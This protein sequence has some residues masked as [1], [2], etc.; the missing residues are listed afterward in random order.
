MLHVMSHT[1]ACLP[2]SGWLSCWLAGWLVEAVRQETHQLCTTELKTPV[3]FV[4]GSDSV[5]NGCLIC[6]WLH[7]NRL[8]ISHAALLWKQ[9]RT[10]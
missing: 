2:G 3:R 10:L 7:N 1:Q 8:Y 9:T 5:V 4:Q 6:T